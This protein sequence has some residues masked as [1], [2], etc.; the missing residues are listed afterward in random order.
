MI[1][2]VLLKTRKIFKHF[3]KRFSVSKL[4]S[5]WR[6]LVKGTVLPIGWSMLKRHLVTNRVLLSLGYM[7]GTFSGAAHATKTAIGLLWLICVRSIGHHCIPLHSTRTSWMQQC[8]QTLSQQSEQVKG[9]TSLGCGGKVVLGSFI[10]CC[11][12]PPSPSVVYAGQM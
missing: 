2:K 3:L 5:A 11:G 6:C 9:V 10:R 8:Y 12:L 4:I 1:V 7:Y